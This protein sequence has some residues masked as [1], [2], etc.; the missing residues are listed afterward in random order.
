ML[1]AKAGLLIST[2]GRAGAQ[3]HA[4]DMGETMARLDQAQDQH[5]ALGEL[6]KQHQAQDASD[7][8]DVAKGLQEQNDAIRGVDA[9]EGS[10]PELA[11]PHIVLAMEVAM[12]VLPTGTPAAK[13]SFSA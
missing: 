8:G 1:R 4:K 7:Q 3:T 6:A 11:E 13:R 2:E 10:F 5:D 12:P 9:E